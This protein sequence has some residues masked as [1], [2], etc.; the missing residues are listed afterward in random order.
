MRITDDALAIRTTAL[1]Y[2]LDN[3]KYDP[4]VFLHVEFTHS[5]QGFNFCPYT[6]GCCLPS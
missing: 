5:F 2:S 1:V 6:P 3:T 4:E